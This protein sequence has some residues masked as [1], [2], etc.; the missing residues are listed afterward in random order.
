V[1]PQFALFRILL[2]PS[3]ELPASCLLLASNML[4]LL[5]WATSA[6]AQSPPVGPS[7]SLPSI[8]HDSMVLQHSQ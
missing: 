1:R 4:H 6:A 5:L 2:P 7:L 8:F 3:S